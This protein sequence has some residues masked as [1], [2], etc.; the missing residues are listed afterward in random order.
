MATLR[1]PG[2]RLAFASPAQTSPRQ[3]GRTGRVGRTRIS[4]RAAARVAAAAGFGFGGVGGMS[5][6]IVGS[7]APIAA[8]ASV[9]AA[10]A[11]LL[12]S[13]GGGPGGG[14]GS[15]GGGGGGGGGNDGRFAERLIDRFFGA[16]CGSC[17]E[18]CAFPMTHRLDMPSVM[19]ATEHVIQTIDAALRK[20]RGTSLAQYLYTYIGRVMNRKS[21]PMRGSAIMALGGFVQYDV[22]RG[23][24]LRVLEYIFTNYVEYYLPGARYNLKNVNTQIFTQFRPLIVSF[25]RGRDADLSRLGAYM[26]KYMLEANNLTSFQTRTPACAICVRM[27]C[28]KNLARQE[29]ERRA[30]GI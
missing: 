19:R 16:S 8:N 15:G 25:L 17:D 1:V 5:T 18:M 9:R 10:F 29:L 20:H 3:T 30:A 11:T 12:R 14:H 21:L 6:P 7:L 23:V 26:M 22:T 27:P 13:L 24:R 4:P 2:Q 28:L